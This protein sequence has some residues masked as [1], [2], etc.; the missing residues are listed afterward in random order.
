M[1]ESSRKH[2][3]QA[4]ESYFE[5]MR[6]AL[7]VGALAVGAGLACIVHAIVPGLCTQSCSRTVALL[8]RLFGDRRQLP[9][10]IRE[11]SGVL[12]FVVLIALSSVIAIAAA[13]ALRTGLLGALVLVQ[14]YA[15]PLIYLSQNPGL[16]PVAAAG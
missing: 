15:L 2:L 3:V 10:V 4:G 5:H 14:A 9:V 6:F 12:V 1:L 8:Q 16:E 7:V 11:S 13:A